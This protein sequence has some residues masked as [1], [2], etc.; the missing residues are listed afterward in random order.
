MNFAALTGD[1]CR[2]CSLQTEEANKAT[3][4]EQEVVDKKYANKRTSEQ[5]NTTSKET[6]K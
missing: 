1:Q 2:A 3:E 5:A 4:E 6:R